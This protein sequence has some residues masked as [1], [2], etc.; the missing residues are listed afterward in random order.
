[1]IPNSLYF[2]KKNYEH[3]SFLVYVGAAFVL[4]FAG[5]GPG[6]GLLIISLFLLA[7]HLV[8]ARRLPEIPTTG[9]WAF[10][11]L[12]WITLALYWGPTDSVHIGQYYKNLVWLNIPI[13]AMLVTTVERRRAVFTALTLGAVVLS[14]RVF[15]SVM[16]TI[17]E[18]RAEGFGADLTD[19]TSYVLFHTQLGDENIIA[20]LVLHGGMQDGQR[21]AVGLFAVIACGWLWSH[22]IK[23]RGWQTAAFVLV[24]LAFIFSFKRGPWVVFGIVCALFAI[25]YLLP[26]SLLRR[27][28]TR[29]GMAG[30]AGMIAVAGLAG[31]AWGHQQGWFERLSEQV[32]DAS[33]EGGRTTMWVEITPALAREYPFGMGFKALSNEMMRN[34]A[35]HVERNQTHVHS[36][37]L[38]SL[39]DG[40]WIGLLLFVAWMV[41]AFRDAI[42]Y[43]RRSIPGSADRVMSVAMLLMLMTLVGMGFVEY[44]LGSGQMVLL[45][46][47]VMGVVAAGARDGKRGIA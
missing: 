40:G 43:I 6:R 7:T 29:V 24:L 10:A 1:M 33:A 34:V 47:T 44:Q 11:Y 19:W 21:L 20:R 17:W 4:M 9:W 14:F 41:S 2:V 28:R 37:A 35:P 15:R 30:L 22:R 27:M 42:H 38:Q 45:Y 5:V 39:I 26:N 25:A 31:W 16:D 36:N 46:G 8:Q 12:I 13:A 18:A 3:A 32:E 23:V